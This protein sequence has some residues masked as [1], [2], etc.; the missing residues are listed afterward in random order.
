[1][2]SLLNVG[3][4]Y[5][6]GLIEAAKQSGVSDAFATNAAWAV[7]LTSGGCVNVLYCLYLMV[8]SNTMKLFFGPETA[9]NLGLGALMG[10]IWCGGLYIYGFGASFMGS[11]GVVVGWVLFMSSIIIVGNLWGIWKGEWEDA[12][13]SARS[14]LNRGLVVLII[15]IIIVAISNTL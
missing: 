12:P 14:L 10:L 11:L 3:F 6:T 7:I 13:P 2:S 5:S 9:R 4:A 8:K 15:A 1:M